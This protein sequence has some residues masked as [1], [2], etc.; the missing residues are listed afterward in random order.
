MFRT[1]GSL[2]AYLS[3]SWIDPAP[4]PIATPETSHKGSATN[5]LELALQRD[6]GR[7]LSVMVA[8]LSMTVPRRALASPCVP[9]FARFPDP[10]KSNRL[11]YLQDPSAYQEHHR[12]E[13]YTGDQ[14]RYCRASRPSPL[15]FP[16]VVLYVAQ[17]IQYV[18]CTYEGEE[19]IGATVIRR[20]YRKTPVLS[21]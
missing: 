14:A 4:R 16:E 5:S 9:S 20:T 8:I 7:T 18:A 1:S 17:Q 21:S 11:C 13:G 10:S 3:N 12:V 2:L 15:D 6:R 19:Y